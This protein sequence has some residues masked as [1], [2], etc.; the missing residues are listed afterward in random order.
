[1]ASSAAAFAAALTKLRESLFGQD[2][3]VGTLRG[4]LSSLI[5]KAG[6]AAVGSGELGLGSLRAEM[7][8]GCIAH[9]RARSD[10]P[11]TRSPILYADLNGVSARRGAS[12]AAT[13]FFTDSAAFPV[14][15]RVLAHALSTASASTPHGRF[16]KLPTRARH[17][18]SRLRAFGR[19]AP[20]GAPGRGGTP[21]PARPASSGLL[22]RARNDLGEN[23][24]TLERARGHH[25]AATRTHAAQRS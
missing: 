21:R 16:K 23:R 20:F 8:L 9:G 19:R 2:P 1:M 7:R 22:L 6:V 14:V 11:P 13:R 4:Y 12:V 10:W 25:V 15:A 3:S 17:R 5:L 24:R 18:R